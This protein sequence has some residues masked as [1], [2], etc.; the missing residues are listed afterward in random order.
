[1]AQLHPAGND[2]FIEVDGGFFTTWPG[3][4]SWCRMFSSAIRVSCPNDC[5][6]MKRYPAGELHMLEL[7]PKHWRG[8][9]FC[10]I[11]DHNALI[12]VKCVSNADTDLG[13][14]L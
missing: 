13:C 14:V 10:K 8:R 4:S 11:S 3:G 7:A 12:G 6:N 5:P 1:M 9:F 2:H